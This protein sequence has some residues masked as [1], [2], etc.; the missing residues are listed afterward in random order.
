MTKG[1]GELGML[2]AN[3]VADLTEKF[4][5]GVGPRPV[6]LPCHEKAMGCLLCG[7]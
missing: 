7:I 1:E 6:C 2:C 5:E 4:P 3:Q